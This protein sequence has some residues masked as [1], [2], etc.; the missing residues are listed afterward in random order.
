MN[1]S[2]QPDGEQKPRFFLG[3][4]PYLNIE[5]FGSKNRHDG[6]GARG[7]ELAGFAFG[8]ALEAHPENDLPLG[9]GQAN[10]SPRFFGGHVQD[11]CERV[12]GEIKGVEGVVVQ[13][14]CMGLGGFR[15]FWPRFWSV[16]NAALIVC[17]VGESASGT[18]GR[19]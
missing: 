7:H 9:V 14:Q 13:H 19:A 18:G 4:G 16:L 15:G 5:G 6:I 3:H 10:K 17:G 11:V 1:L 8:A 12:G 2:F